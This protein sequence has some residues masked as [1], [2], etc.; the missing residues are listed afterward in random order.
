M[1]RSPETPFFRASRPGDGLA[2]ATTPSPSPW[3]SDHGS[4]SARL[5]RC[6]EGTG[7]S[8]LSPSPRFET[9]LDDTHRAP[10]P[11]W[12]QLPI[13]PATQGGIVAFGRW[14]VDALCRR[15]RLGSPPADDRATAFVPGQRGSGVGPDRRAQLRI[16][17]LSRQH[18]RDPGGFCE[19]RGRLRLAW[20][21]L[22]L[23]VCPS[24]VM[25]RVGERRAGHLRG[26]G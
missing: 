9:Q 20:R 24:P 12:A 10:S 4:H 18:D 7:R 15:W 22:G 3:P 2:S 25:L 8:A 1:P 5:R 23:T 26:W 19:S 16:A 6:P 21:A 11:R 17:H 13:A 14:S